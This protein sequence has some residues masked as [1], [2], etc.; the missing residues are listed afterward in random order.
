MIGVE[1]CLVSD[2]M[3]RY[4]VYVHFE[5]IHDVFVFQSSDISGHATFM[6]TKV[7]TQSCGIQ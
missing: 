4:R 6:F 1:L 3:V 2:F 5:E 7:Y